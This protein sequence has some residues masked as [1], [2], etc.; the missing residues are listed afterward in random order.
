MYKI[1]SLKVSLGKLVYEYVV[2]VDGVLSIK[3][4][5]IEADNRAIHSAYTVRRKN[6]YV[7]YENCQ[8]ATEYEVENE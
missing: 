4:E 8:F 3:N 5:T 6:N 7:T 1:K 2:G